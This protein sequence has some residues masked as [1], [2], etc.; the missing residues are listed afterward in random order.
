MAGGIFLHV[1]LRAAAFATLMS[2]VWLRRMPTPVS[3]EPSINTAILEADT[4]PG[5][6]VDIGQADRPL[7]AR[8]DGV[9]KGQRQQ[10]IGRRAHLQEQVGASFA[11]S[12]LGGLA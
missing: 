8:N 1:D 4:Q 5:C 11:G 10:F 12:G 2:V 3:A 6:P 7:R 9:L